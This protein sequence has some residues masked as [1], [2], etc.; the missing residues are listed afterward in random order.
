MKIDL[1]IAAQAQFFMSASISL[2]DELKGMQ[3]T[4]KLL[5]QRL[6]QQILLLLEDYLHQV[7]TG[8]TG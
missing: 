4:P 7:G 2:T 6:K 1:S 5:I 8:L 3:I